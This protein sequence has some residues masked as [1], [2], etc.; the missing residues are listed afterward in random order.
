MR[1]QLYPKPPGGIQGMLSFAKAAVQ[2]VQSMSHSVQNIGSSV[3]VI[4][5][6]VVYLPDRIGS[7]TRAAN[8]K[9]DLNE[10]PG[11]ML[12]PADLITKAGYAVE[13]ATTRAGGVVNAIQ[14][15]LDTVDRVKNQVRGIKDAASNIA[16]GFNQLKQ[17]Y[18]NWGKE[19]TFGVMRGKYYDNADE[20]T[21][22]RPNPEQ[23]QDPE[24]VDNLVDATVQNAANNAVQMN[25]VDTIQDAALDKAQNGSGGGAQAA[26]KP[27]TL[28][29]VNISP[30]IPLEGP[31]QGIEAEHPL[32][33]EKLQQIQ[34]PVSGQ[35]VQPPLGQEYFTVENQTP[36]PA[37]ATAQTDLSGTC[38]NSSCVVPTPH[39]FAFEAGYSRTPVPFEGPTLPTG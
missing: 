3:N 35:S 5:Q 7:I 37:V 31:T 16:G 21:G 25:N 18:D 14:E 30:T 28:P 4:K 8:T 36:A 2:Q 17:L 12:W 10:P 20:W 23:R 1:D 19:P 27:I 26:Q 6:Q 38:A 39:K 9:A 13:N 11:G 22:D 33:P 32:T 34:N 29:E 15:P 24:E